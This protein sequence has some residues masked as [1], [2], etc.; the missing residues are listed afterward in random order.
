MATGTW[1]SG[2]LVG[3]TLALQMMSAMY[4]GVFFG[5]YLLALAPLAWVAGDKKRR[6]RAIG[7]TAA[8][9]VVAGIVLI[10]SLRPYA[11]NPGAAPGQE[12][13][14]VMPGHAPS[15]FRT[16]VF[17]PSPE[18][19]R[20]K[21]SYRPAGRRGDARG[22]GPVMDSRRNGQAQWVV[23]AALLSATLAA[24][25]STETA[26]DVAKLKEF[27]AKYTAAWCSQNAASVAAF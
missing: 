19:S 15:S 17:S 10:P 23:V 1:Q 13:V 20:A 14:R 4:Y 26:M 6:N 25:D 22:E 18:R 8:G 7:R 11:R 27:G 12:R 2:S 5:V 3:A 21:K 24:C 9:L 16:A